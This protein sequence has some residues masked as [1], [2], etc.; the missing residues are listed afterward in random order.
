MMLLLKNGIKT[1]GLIGKA[2]AKLR[3]GDYDDFLKIVNEVPSENLVLWNNGKIKMGN[4]VSQESGDCDFAALL[5]SGPAIQKFGYKIK[6]IFKIKKDP[7]LI[8]DVFKKAAFLEIAISMHHS[9]LKGIYTKDSLE[10]K[11][12]D[13]SIKRELTE[14]EIRILHLGRNAVNKIKRPETR[15]NIKILDAPSMID[16]AIE[17]LKKYDLVVGQQFS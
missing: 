11:I 12:R 17:V 1:E 10:D 3:H 8:F 6:S 15:G 4:E 9:N 14:E 2:F 13:L 5:V 7:D 16:K